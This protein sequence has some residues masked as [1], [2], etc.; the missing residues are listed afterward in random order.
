MLTLATSSVLCSTHVPI[1]VVVKVGIVV[2]VVETAVVLSVNIDTTPVVVTIVLVNFA[3][4]PKNALQNCDAV[5]H[6]L[7]LATFVGKA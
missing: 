7:S 5:A 1:E 4:P 2:A 6:V 3:G